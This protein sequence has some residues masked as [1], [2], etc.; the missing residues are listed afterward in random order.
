MITLPSI[1]DSTNKILIA[2]GLAVIA[3]AT[4]KRIEV[5]NEARL[6]VKR[7][8]TLHDSAFIYQTEIA[9]GTDNL[10]I[11]AKRISQKR[12]APPL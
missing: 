2:I 9:I 4:I 6:L 5:N 12:A 11:V 7:Y 8:H 3:F 10:K 1:P